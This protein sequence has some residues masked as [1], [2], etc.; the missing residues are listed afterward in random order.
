MPFYLIPATFGDE[1]NYHHPLFS[2][3]QEADSE[4]TCHTAS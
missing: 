3:E 2:D 4:N 1:L